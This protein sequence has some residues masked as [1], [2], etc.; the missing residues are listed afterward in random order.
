MLIPEKSW[1]AKYQRMGKHSIEQRACERK[2]HHPEAGPMQPGLYAAIVFGR[3]PKYVLDRLKDEG[4]PYIPRDDPSGDPVEPEYSDEEAEEDD[5]ELEELA[6]DRDFVAD[7]DAE[8]EQGLE[9]LRYAGG[10]RPLRGD[11]ESEE[12][13]PAPRRRQDEDDDDDE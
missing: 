3:P 2:S 1:V 10:Q 6:A 7:D 8:E 11:S 12:D 9:G 5:E 13:A 4:V